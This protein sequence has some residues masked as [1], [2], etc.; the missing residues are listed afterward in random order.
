[1]FKN[2]AI[3][4]LRDHF[5]ADGTTPGL[6]MLNLRRDFPSAWSRFLNPTNSADG[7]VFELEVSDALFPVRDAGKTL[8]VNA[9]T[10]LARC[11]QDGD[12]GVSLSPPL[13][14]SPPAAS[15]ISLGKNTAFGGLHA[16]A[17]DVTDDGVEIAPQ[18]LP[19]TWR[20]AVERPGGGLLTEDPVTKVP[21]MQ[22]LLMV[23][24][25]EW[26]G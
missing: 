14:S 10:L 25:Y 23:L 11:E 1:V 12:Y 26:V 4:N 6:L 24:G 18:D 21:E 7:N 19:A 8:K 9:V 20:I 15:A 3:V 16:G 22:D 17:R 2:D 5:T 13:P